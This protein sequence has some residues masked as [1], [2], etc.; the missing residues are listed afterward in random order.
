M[1]NGAC[2]SADGVPTATVPT[3]NLCTTGNET[4]VTTNTGTY[5]WSCSGVNGGTTD[6]CTANRQKVYACAAKPTIGTAW[7]TVS[8]YT[9]TWSGSAWLP[10]N[11][12]T[13]YNATASTT[14]CRYKCASGYAWD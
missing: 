14:S 8:S 3:T 9:Q 6:S 4:T 2:G 7:N 1:V 10:A 5:T 13:A 12:T 11:S